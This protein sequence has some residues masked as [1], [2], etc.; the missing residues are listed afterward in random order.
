MKNKKVGKQR[1]PCKVVTL[2]LTKGVQNT[3]SVVS[4]LITHK[5]ANFKFHFTISNI[6]VNLLI[7]SII[8]DK[9]II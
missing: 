9:N 6:K 8:K 5:V 1:T 4:F 7:I 2:S 3:S